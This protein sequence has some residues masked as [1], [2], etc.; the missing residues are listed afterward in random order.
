MERLEG[1][2]RTHT[3]GVLTGKNEG[4]STLLMGW[5]HRRRDHGGLIFID[6]RDRYGI[7]QVVFDPSKEQIYQRG[8]ELRG[9][10]V[11]AVKGQ[12][13]QRPEGMKNP[14]MA[15]GEIE[16]AVQELKILSSAKT[17]PFGVDDIHDI[18]EELRLKYRY[19]DLRNSDKQ[20]SLWIRH[21]AYQV[22][23]AFFSHNDF[24]EIETPM[25]MRGTPEGARNYLVPSRIHKGKFY[26]LPQ[27]PQTYKQILMI[28]G[29]DRYFQ[30]V[31]C[32]RD[33]ALRADRQPEFT[34]IDVEMSFVERDDVMQI[35]EELM[36]EIFKEILQI[37]IKLPIRKM[38]YEEALTTY[39]SDKPDLRFGLKIVDVSEQVKESD[40]KVFSKNIEAGGIVC[41]VCLENGAG[42]SRKQIDDLTQAMVSEGAKG[43]V[44][45]KVTDEGWDASV[46]KFFSEEE[47]RAV[48][49]AFGAKS[50]D[51]ILLL[52]DAREKA[53]TLAGTLRLN[54]A[55][56][57]NLIPDDQY[58][59]VWIIDFPLMEF[60][61][62][63]Q[64]YVARHHP[65]TAPL[66]EDIDLLE[67][68]PEAARAKAYDLVLNGY[69]LAGGSIRIHDRQ[70]QNRMF[71]ALGINEEEA[72][73]K[74]GFLLEAL[75]YG[76]PP[77]GGIAFG[78]DRLVMLLAGQK[79]IR[80]VIAFPKTTTAQ[81]LMD[82]AP[83]EATKEQLDELHL[84]II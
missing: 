14:N 25:L 33:E 76:A 2:K 66:D 17:P 83:S 44:A 19:L 40:F 42:Y 79:S 72:Q 22:V 65:F 58:E 77:H 75:E 18:S 67:Q 3:C 28:A 48:N 32:F 54:L 52:S 24:L 20:R 7:T 43:L 71:N 49:Q 13:Q 61:E 50:G 46:S 69:E 6:L 70:L 11:I 29:F 30:I 41:G 64:R 62:D 15:T 68:Q 57:E 74:F 80:D 16:V 21:E 59:L 47:V 10:F 78:F 81:S 84:K 1:W 35:V 8:K 4:E 9:E 73:D 39:G 38:G 82:S 5:V 45:L 34:Q 56:Q 12:V 60:D 55:K 27:S 31:R 26:A 36:G 51:L 53:L 63:E 37:E 23:R